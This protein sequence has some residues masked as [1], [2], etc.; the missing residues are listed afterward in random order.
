MELDRELKKLIEQEQSL[1][2]MAYNLSVSDVD[3]MIEKK[4]TDENEID[5][6][7]DRIL[8]FITDEKFS[9]LYEKVISY[10]DNY[11]RE[12]AEGYRKLKNTFLAYSGD[13]YDAKFFKGDIFA[14]NRTGHECFVCHPMNI[15]GIMCHVLDERLKSIYP[16]FF[17]QSEYRLMRT[18]D[19]KSLLGS[20]ML[21]L[22]HYEGHPFTIVTMFVRDN[23]KEKYFDHNALREA[24][25]NTCFIA[26]PLPAR[27]L[28]TV[29][30]PYKMGC[31]ISF[32]EWEEVYQIIQDELIEKGIPVE[33][34]Q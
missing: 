12:L 27:T 13:I 32:E 26:K 9:A 31:D 17:E 25:R 7:I 30:V 15:N 24:F 34:W 21:Q 5:T 14:P 28:T 1:R 22:I 19:K 3:C 2:K 33:I 11:D 18:K 6:V 23:S 8:N 20:V 10:V 4:I 16:L 29:R